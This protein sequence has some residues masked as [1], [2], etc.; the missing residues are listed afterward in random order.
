MAKAEYAII[1]ARV[2]VINEVSNLNKEEK[3]SLQQFFLNT[4][5]DQ[6]KYTKRSR[7]RS[8][9]GEIIDISKLSEVILYNNRIDY[10]NKGQDFF[11]DIFTVAVC[12]RFLPLKMDGILNKDQFKDRT[13]CKKVA[14]ENMQNNIAMMK[15]VMWLSEGS[16]NQTHN[17]LSLMKNYKKSVELSGRQGNSFDT[18]M[19]F[20]DLYADTQEEFTIMEHMLHN[21]Y[22]DYKEQLK[23]G[24]DINIPIQEEIVK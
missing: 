23:I 5:A 11:D 12:D 16:D 7:A 2:L 10:L 24:E 18:I 13:D 15:T 17:Y 21:C 9:E 3:K 8:V 4:A 14:T 6:P 19:R 20:V 22:N 1:G